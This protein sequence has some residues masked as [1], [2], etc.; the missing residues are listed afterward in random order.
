MWFITMVLIRSKCITTILI[1]TIKL[2]L[3]YCVK[4]AVKAT[5][6]S[7]HVQPQ[8][9]DSNFPSTGA[10]TAQRHLNPWLRVCAADSHSAYQASAFGVMIS[11]A[12]NK[13]LAQMC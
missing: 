11:A 3:T 13:P 9:V 2:Y 7:S 4:N 1:F 12:L 6:W 10:A 8:L 5:H